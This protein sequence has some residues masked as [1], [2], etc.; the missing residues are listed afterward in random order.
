MARIDATA[1]APIIE[2][3]ED[4]VTFA[5]SALAPARII[6]LLDGANEAQSTPVL[7]SASSK[8]TV[9]E[10]KGTLSSAA[11]SIFILDFYASLVA[12]EGQAY[13]G[14]ITGQSVGAVQIDR[15]IR[16]I[17]W[18]I[19]VLL[20]LALAYLVTAAVKQPVAGAQIVWGF[21]GND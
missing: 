4:L 12:G 3:S 15:Q 14:S 9:T 18:L 8:G 17:K 5:Q 13:L 20:G 1:A 21:Q 11:N 10:I 7:I 16:W 6:E 19:V 2:F